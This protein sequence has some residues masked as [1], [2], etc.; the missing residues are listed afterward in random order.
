MAVTPTETTGEVQNPERP[1]APWRD[2]IFGWWMVVVFFC[3]ALW[4]HQGFGYAA[5]FQALIV[6]DSFICFRAV[7]AI[8]GGNTSRWWVVYLAL[9]FILIPITEI[10]TGAT[11]HFG[12]GM[13]SMH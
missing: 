6:A 2:P 4:L 5:N 1:V 10:V 7:M 13:V 3:P 9:Y 8:A 11:W 12:G